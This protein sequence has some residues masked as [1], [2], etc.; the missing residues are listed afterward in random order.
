MKVGDGIGLSIVYL[1]A[2]AVGIIGIVYIISQAA[3]GDQ[4]EE[5]LYLTDVDF[6]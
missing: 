1:A 5:P 3:T 2:I 4:P 6:F